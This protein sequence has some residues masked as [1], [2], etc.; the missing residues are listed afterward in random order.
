[1]IS[2]LAIKHTGRSRWQL[3]RDRME[4]KGLPFFRSDIFKGVQV[5]YLAS[6]ILEPTAP[7]WIACRAHLA[8]AQ[9]TDP[10]ASPESVW[11]ALTYW[12][13]TAPQRFRSSALTTRP[14]RPRR[15]IQDL[16]AAFMASVHN[17]PI[18]GRIS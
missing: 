16:E 6:A 7:L 12:Q 14:L 15:L 1:M 2:N 13:I 3:A 9:L 10:N 11:A 18:S 5:Y 8:S 17:S 4:G